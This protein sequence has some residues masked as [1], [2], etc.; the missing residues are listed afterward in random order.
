MYVFYFA[1]SRM[2]MSE[3]RVLFSLFFFLVVLWFWYFI[4]VK[5]RIV[6]F[7]F[8][9][10]SRSRIE[11]NVT[12]ITKSPAIGQPTR[13]FYNIEVFLCLQDTA[14]E[15]KICEKHIAAQ[16]SKI[17][18]CVFDLRYAFHI[19]FLLLLFLTCS[20][21]VVLNPNFIK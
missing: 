3:Y 9:Y 20:L 5:P 11:Y 14:S 16:P 15:E 1:D 12:G 10:R 17:N 8:L 4:F 6:F 19:S 21:R 18:I 13:N 7:F 2:M